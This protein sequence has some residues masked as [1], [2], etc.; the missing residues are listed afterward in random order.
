MGGAIWESL[1]VDK[2]TATIKLRH[3]RMTGWQDVEVPALH[4]AGDHIVI[5]RH[6][7]L[8]HE[9]A[10]NTAGGGY[11]ISHG[12]SGSLLFETERLGDAKAAAAAIEALDVDW[13]KA[14]PFVDMPQSAKLAAIE[15]KQQYALWRP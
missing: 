9:G 2:K 6:T 5:H 8:D 11:T 13:S 12:P 3:P 14:N 10:L 4:W 1:T 7:T 15:L